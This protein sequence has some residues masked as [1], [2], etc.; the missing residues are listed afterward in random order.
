MSRAVCAAQVSLQNAGGYANEGWPRVREA[1]DMKCWANAMHVPTRK[2]M[3]TI[4]AIEG[5]L[6]ES[7]AKARAKGD[8]AFPTDVS[9]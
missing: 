2:P 1:R 7:P 6:P 9:S 8:A 5:A 3:P 4:A